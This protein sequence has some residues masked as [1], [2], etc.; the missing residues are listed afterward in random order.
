[1]SNSEVNEDLETLVENVL[2]DNTDAADE[3]TDEDVERPT[4]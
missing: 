2:D 3:T 1:M 4:R